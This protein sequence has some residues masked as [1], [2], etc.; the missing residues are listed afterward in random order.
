VR[1]YGG[2]HDNIDPQA[3]LVLQ[4]IRRMEYNEGEKR[5]DLTMSYAKDHGK[6]PHSTN[7]DGDVVEGNYS[8]T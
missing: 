4:S 1:D 6:D 8:G 2:H 7:I 5:M 3:S